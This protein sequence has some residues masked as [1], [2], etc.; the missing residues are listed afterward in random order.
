MVNLPAV[1]SRC[2][3]ITVQNFWVRAE[4]VNIS[5]VV[6]DCPK[7]GRPA[8]IVDGSYKLGDDLLRAIRAPGVNRG[9]IEEFRAKV[10]AVR[11][12]SLP[13]DDATRA[14]SEINESFGQ[15]L[16]IIGQNYEALGVLLALLMLLTTWY[17]IWSSSQDSSQAHQDFRAL[18]E[19]TAKQTQAL[20]NVQQEETKLQE[21]QRQI[22][23]QIAQLNALSPS[24]KRPMQAKKQRTQ[25]SPPQTLSSPKNRHERRKAM[26]LSRR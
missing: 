21:A 17:Q 22:D 5:N 3:P 2:G 10:E 18:T 13:L 12:G 16:K 15:I 24:L 23:E 1:C 4:R 6:V 20:V 11:S 25:S 7:C 14:A 26:S 9:N 8:N 19:A